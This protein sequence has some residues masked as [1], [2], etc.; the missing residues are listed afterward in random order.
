MRP[1]KAFT[2]IE[3]IVVMTVIAL[4]SAVAMIDY[5]MSVKKARLQVATEELGLLFEDAGVRTQSQMGSEGVAK[6]WLIEVPIGA[7]PVLNSVE[8]NDGC[9]FSAAIE[10]ENLAWDK[11][12]ILKTSTG[13]S[14]WFMF[15]PPDGDISVYNDSGSIITESPLQITLSYNGSSE[16]IF[17]KTV[18]ITPV[19]AN[20]VIY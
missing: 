5:G 16:E 6:C 7:A 2:L 12:E 20:F 3:L 14:L 19:T 15:S 1:P 11:V 17:T 10:E 9:S 13:D 18:E 4:L 8:W